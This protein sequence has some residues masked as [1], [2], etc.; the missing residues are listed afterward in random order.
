MPARTT[1]AFAARPRTM[2]AAR[3]LRILSGLRRCIKGVVDAE[4]DE[5]HGHRVPEI[6]SSRAR[7]LSV[8]SPEM[9]H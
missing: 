5:E 4:L 6:L 3:L 1:R 7:P 8:E 9:R 2:H